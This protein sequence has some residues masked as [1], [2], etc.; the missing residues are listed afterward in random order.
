ML[1]QPNP[2]IAS[3]LAG[4][5]AD[6]GWAA[7]ARP[8]QMPPPGDW[9][10]IWL[11]LAGRG[12]GKTR[13][14]AEWVK[15]LIE[16]TAVG[17]V[18][19]VGPTAA[20]VRDTML[21]GES[22][23]LSIS[24]PWCRPEYEP[25][26]RR[27][28]W[29]NGATAS[30]FSA[31]EPDR[32]RGPN[33]E[34]AWC[35][36]LAAWADPQAV[37]DMLQFTLRLG[38][39]P[40]VCATTTPRPIAL[41]KNLV[42]REGQDVVVTRGSTF[43]NVDNLSPPFLQAMKA[44]YEGTR[45]GRQELFADVLSDT[46]GALWAQAWIDRDRIASAS[47]ADFKRIVVAIDPAVTSGENAD[48]TGII[49]AAIGD[50]G[51]AYV[52]EDVSGK[53]AP[54]EWAA[55]AIGLYRRYNADRIIGETNNGGEMIENVLRSIDQSVSYKSVHASRGRVVRAEPI[56]ALYEQGRVHH[57]GTFTQLEDQM[58]AFT[59]DF[60]RATAGYSPDRLDAL[61]WALTELMLEKRGPKLF[62]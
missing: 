26:K 19:L 55:K 10:G 44:R 41:V 14:G 4:V 49:C 18:A 31:E 34:A 8:S 9:W 5:L 3:Q 16:S 15:S 51:H 2:T 32:L 42:K 1:H 47:W 43:E 11:I 17:R 37:W 25:S 46:P 40:R 58:T 56:S 35:D 50:D 28:T 12:F 59:S 33:F 54:H 23:L 29:P 48:E 57:V 45:L 60:S 39:H 30:L 7:K 53:Y 27:L 22:G 52:L 6:G 13:T 62:F 38:K 61:V 20:D 36:E 21:E 24:S